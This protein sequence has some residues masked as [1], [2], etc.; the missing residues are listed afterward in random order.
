MAKNISFRDFD[1][2]LL[3]LC[4]VICALGTA[5]IYSAT[6]N[7]PK[8]AEAHLHIK[9][10]YWVGAG[11]AL[12]FLISIVNYEVLLDNAPWFYL[13]A[14]LSLMSVLV[15]GRKVLGARRWI[16]LPG[17]V[18]FQPSEWVKLILVLAIAR[19]FMELRHRELSLGEL[20][21]AGLIILVPFALVM[22]Q[23]D[24]GTALTYLPPLFMGLFLGG[25]KL[26]HALVMVL[27]VGMAAPIAYRHIK[28]YQRQRLTSFMHPEE[29][30]QGSGY[31]VEQ[32]KIAVGAGGIWG[33]GLTKGSQTQGSFIPEPHNDFIMA[34][35]AEE[36]GFVG[37]V[38]LLLLYFLVLMRLIHNAQTASD[39]AGTFVVMGIVAVL[40][41]H[42]LINVGMV[43]GFMP[44]TGIP[45]PLMS[46][47]GSSVL[48]MFLAL[49]IV[50][51]IRMRRFVN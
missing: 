37:A 7:A 23:P 43:V 29:D 12:M 3:A 35:F 15:L 44:V 25:M 6:I 42:V 21:K 27:L 11:L 46:Y 19:F 45:L 17:G 22:K 39:G 18:H 10:M 50:N 13:A 34:A 1:W 4:L 28:P 40:A 49:G 8:F 36:H 32:A 38:V 16:A 31:Q 48:F 9:Q 5:Q 30:S 24:M 51:N 41:F 20:A 2:V 26:K 33:R 14:I 47:G